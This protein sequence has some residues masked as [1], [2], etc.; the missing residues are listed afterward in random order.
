MEHR[1]IIYCERQKRT[2]LEFRHE[3]TAIGRKQANKKF[4]NCTFK[5]IHKRKAPRANV[6]SGS[7]AFRWI[8][9]TNEWKTGD[10]DDCVNFACEATIL[11]AR[12][13]IET[14]NGSH[15][16]EFLCF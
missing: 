1:I 13:S 10:S 12:S 15:T 7:Q 16:K 9:H 4:Q 6:P 2:K 3:V 11:A 8:V 5:F 14:N